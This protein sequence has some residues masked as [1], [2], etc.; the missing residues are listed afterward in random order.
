[1]VCLGF[2]RGPARWEAQTSQMIYGS[3]L[4]YIC[5][6]SIWHVVGLSSRMCRL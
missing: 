2:K 4:L 6:Q 3:P 1:M 5:I